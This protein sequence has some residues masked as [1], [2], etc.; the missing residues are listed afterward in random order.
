MRRSPATSPLNDAADI[1]F[2]R[3]AE[4]LADAAALVGVWL[5]V[6]LKDLNSLYQF[7]SRPPDASKAALM[8]YSAH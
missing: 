6:E 7:M 5:D 1:E 8:P 2:A 4:L 3:I